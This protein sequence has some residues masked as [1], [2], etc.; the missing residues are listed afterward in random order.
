VDNGEGKRTSFTA[1]TVILQGLEMGL[2]PP[3][4]Y[5]IKAYARQTNIDFSR[6]MVAVV[7]LYVVK[8]QAWGHVR[9]LNCPWLSFEGHGHVPWPFLFSPK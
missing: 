8:P 3:K 5:A 7:Q 6:R 1:W 2:T 4:T 9:F